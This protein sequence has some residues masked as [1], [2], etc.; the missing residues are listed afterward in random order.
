MNNILP[1]FLVIKIIKLILKTKKMKILKILKITTIILLIPLWVSAQTLN[2]PSTLKMRRATA[3]Y[4]FNSLS[5][6]AQCLTGKNY[7]FILTLY[8]GRDYRLSFFA[9]AVFNNNIIF[10]LVNLKTNETILDLPGEI[11]DEYGDSNKKTALV[12]K[13]DR[14]GRVIHPHFDIIPEYTTQ[15]KVMI[16]VAS[17]GKKTSTGYEDRKRGCITVFIQDKKAEAIGF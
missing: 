5:K 4:K 9:S 6:S 7:D 2:C 16:N 15:F 1:L 3:P 11:K 14:N 13:T 8:Q 12:G 17:T 10:K